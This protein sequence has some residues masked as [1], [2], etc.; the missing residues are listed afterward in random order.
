[1]TLP[2]GSLHLSIHSLSTDAH[3]GLTRKWPTGFKVRGGGKGKGKISRFSFPGGIYP[4]RVS[5]TALSPCT[6]A[7]L[8]TSR[9]LFPV[10]NE[11]KVFSAPSQLWQYKCPFPKLQGLGIAACLLTSAWLSPLNWE[12]MVGS[13]A[14]LGQ[15]GWIALTKPSKCKALHGQ[16]D[17]ALLT[18]P[19][20]D[21]RTNIPEH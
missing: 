12:K 21:E 8:S 6:Q 4:S 18:F 7:K 17:F 16:L 9:A 3:Q 1:M 14:I 10:G 19:Q 13:R 5:L 15:T 20:R 2:L 11:E